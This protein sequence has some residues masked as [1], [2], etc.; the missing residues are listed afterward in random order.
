MLPNYIG[1]NMFFNINKYLEG[2]FPFIS[3]SCMAEACA[4]SGLKVFPCK[5]TQKSPAIAGGHHSASSD[6]EVVGN[7]WKDRPNLNIGLP[8][9]INGLVAV[10]VDSQKREYKSRVPIDRETWW[11]ATPSGGRHQIYNHGGHEFSGRLT[12]DGEVQE[13]VDIKHNGYIL[14]AP[15]TVGSKHYLT[16]NL[17]C[18]KDTPEWLIEGASRQTN[19]P[20]AGHTEAPLSVTLWEVENA[21]SEL[22]PDLPYH[23][24]L[25]VLMGVHSATSGSDDGLRSV[26]QWS[27]HGQKFTVYEAQVIASKWAGFQSNGGITFKTVKLMAEAARWGI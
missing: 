24:W 3:N 1:N 5:S 16:E 15:S 4:K 7:W 27:K 14:I 25:K 23:D 17:G 11:Q 21:L 20:L 8:L 12:L 10:D 13:A 18:A 2:V 19:M 9:K 22:D 6:P 26:I